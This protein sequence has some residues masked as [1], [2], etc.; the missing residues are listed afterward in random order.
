MIL[1][2]KNNPEKKDVLITLADKNYILY[3]KQLFSSVYWNAGWRGDY[4]LLAHDIPEK[5]LEWFTDKGILVKRCQ[6]LHDKNIGKENYPPVVLNIFYLFTPEFKK[7]KNIIFLDADI[8]VR[9][10]L[11]ALTK[12]RGFASPT[13]LGDKLKYYFYDDTDSGQFTMLNKKYNLNVSPFNCAVMAFST[14]IIKEG[15]LNDLMQIYETYHKVSSGADPTLNQYFY[16]KWKRLPIVFDITPEKIEKYTSISTNNVKGIIIH[17]KDN[18]LSNKKSS[19]YQ[20]WKTNLEKADFIDLTKTPKGHNWNIFKI[21]F[22]SSVLIIKYSKFKINFKVLN[23]FNNNVKSL[24][25]NRVKPFFTYK[26]KM[27]FMYTL[28]TPD[29]L[30]GKIGI[31]IKKRNPDLYQKLKK[32]ISGE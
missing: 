3:A 32:I 12:V 19:L 10:S 14:D 16:K 17:L 1:I 28:K 25:I 31:C 22:Y 15:I 2:D 6:P 27:F 9:A 21:H 11:D 30:L 20:E 23:F 7:W 5:E 26:L 4:M 8:I 13:V 29:R 24:F 18:E